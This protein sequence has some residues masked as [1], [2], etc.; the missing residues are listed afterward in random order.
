MVYSLALLELRLQFCRM[1]IKV[2]FLSWDSQKQESHRKCPAVKPVAESI[3]NS[4]DKPEFL[5]T[6]PVYEHLNVLSVSLRKLL[7]PYNRFYLTGYSCLMDHLQLV[8]AERIVG[9][10]HPLKQIRG[11]QHQLN[12]SIHY[13]FER[14]PRMCEGFFHEYLP[15]HRRLGR[16][17]FQKTLACREVVKQAPDLHDRS[18]GPFGGTALHLSSFFNN[19][20]SAVIAIGATCNFQGRNCRDTCER[21]S[22]KAETLDTKQIVGG[23]HFARA[24]GEIASIEIRITHTRTVIGDAKKAKPALTKFDRNRIRFGVDAVIKKLA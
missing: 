11:R 14:N 2:D 4:L 16:G 20:S 8:L 23:T 21:L 9:S 5:D 10:G 7:S 15:A 12:G 1:N 6:S 17:T 18:R 24:M 22:A 3:F 13:K 19:T